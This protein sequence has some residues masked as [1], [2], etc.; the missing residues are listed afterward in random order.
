MLSNAWKDASQKGVVMPKLMLIAGLLAVLAACATVPEAQTTTLVSKDAHDYTCVQTGTRIRLE[1]GEC[2]PQAG[3]N[4][5][6]DELDRAGGLT[7]AESLRRLDPSIG[8]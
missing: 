5:T 3:R 4:Y 6:R 8:F 7:L 1:E 2:A